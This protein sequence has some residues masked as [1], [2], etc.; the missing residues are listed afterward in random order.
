MPCF[1]GLLFINHLK[2]AK[3]QKAKRRQGRI[4][5]SLIGGEKCSY[6]HVQ[7]DGK[8]NRYQNRLPIKLPATA[9]ECGGK[10][11]CLN[12]YFQITF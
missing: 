1:L 2:N 7:I 10:N 4:A 11:K 8:T 9:S 12:D 3:F 5:I 6:F